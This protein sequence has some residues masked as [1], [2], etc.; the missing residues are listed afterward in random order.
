M[1]DRHAMTPLIPADVLPRVAACALSDHGFA[2][3][4]LP[5]DESM[6]E[7]GHRLGTLV[8]AR[9]GQDALSLL[10]PTP[11]EEAPARSLSSMHGIG[12]FPFHTLVPVGAPFISTT[13]ASPKH[14]RADL[15]A[16]P[17]AIVPI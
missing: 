5:D 16:R 10:T 8:S 15:V 4:P 12:H 3:L 9:A 11:K 6:L 2:E 1:H 13:A 7:L 14:K 17:K